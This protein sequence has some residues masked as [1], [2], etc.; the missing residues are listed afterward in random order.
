MQKEILENISDYKNSEEL[1][2]QYD[3]KVR[4]HEDNIKEHERLANLERTY[5]K[6]YSLYKTSNTNQIEKAKEIFKM[7]EYET[8]PETEP[9]IQPKTEPNKE[10]K[11][12]LP[13]DNSTYSL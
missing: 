11:N 3:E 10:E 6:A 12:E 4:E 1:I 13:A 8:Q 5:Q 7:P 9:D 2:E